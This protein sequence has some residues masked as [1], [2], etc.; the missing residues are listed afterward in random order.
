MYHETLC[1]TGHCRN[2][3]EITRGDHFPLSRMA[4]VKRST[5]VSIDEDTE[6]KAGI[7]RIFLMGMCQLVSR[8]FLQL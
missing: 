7:F 6:K 8:F 2:A 1:I 3:S 5:T 4:K